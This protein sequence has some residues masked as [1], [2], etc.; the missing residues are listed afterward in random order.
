MSWFKLLISTWFPKCL[1]NPPQA[2]KQS[3][4]WH[5]AVSEPM[6]YDLKITGMSFIWRSTTPAL[7]RPGPHGQGFVK[8]SE[9]FY[10]FVAYS[11]AGPVPCAA[12]HRGPCGPASCS[13]WARAFALRLCQTGGLWQFPSRWKTEA[14]ILSLT[15]A[16]PMLYRAL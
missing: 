16:M 13:S 14:E 1:Y 6:R 3:S 2:S 8:D 4:M 15:S 5:T 10:F 12:C 9:G 11:C 7:G